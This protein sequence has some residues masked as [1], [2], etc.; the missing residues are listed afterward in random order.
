LIASSPRPFNPVDEA[1]ILAHSERWPA[2]LQILCHTRLTALEEGQTGDT[3][4]EE[5]LRR[6]APYRYL[7]G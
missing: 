2:L 7:L 1:W 3:W 5:G 6:I 4:R